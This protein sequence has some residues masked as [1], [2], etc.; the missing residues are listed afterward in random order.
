MV[1]VYFKNSSNVTIFML[2]V[3]LTPFT[4]RVNRITCAHMDCNRIN[5]DFHTRELN[6]F[7]WIVK[8][9]PN[10]Y[11]Y[12]SLTVNFDKRW[13]N[14]KKFIPVYTR[15]VSRFFKW[16]VKAMHWGVVLIYKWSKAWLE[17]ILSFLK[18]F[19][20]SKLTF[21]KKYVCFSVCFVPA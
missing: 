10:I 13:I 1:K 19:E 17:I 12:I 14:K 18:K 3:C 9:M 5:Q 15:V 7:C 4:I 21:C 2:Y 6:V 11:S 20:G 16:R 8:F